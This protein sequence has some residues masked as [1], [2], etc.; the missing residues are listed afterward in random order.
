MPTKLQLAER[1]EAIDRLRELLKPG[2]EVRTILR[3]VARSGMS[4]AIDCYVIRD[5][6]TLRITWDVALATG[7]RYSNRW[8][9]VDMGGCGMDMGFALV[10]ALSRALYP[11]G[12]DCIGQD[13]PSND[14]S[15][16]RGAR[17]YSP[18]RHHES[19]GYALRQR[20]M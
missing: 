16:D 6:D 10:Y 7:Y 13:C 11:H 14:H 12:F 15:N 8:D 3:H 9:A 1:D 19:G 20:W 18:T 2:D 4:R 17:D 5:S